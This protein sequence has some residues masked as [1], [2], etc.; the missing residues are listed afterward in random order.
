MAN[1]LLVVLGNSEGFLNGHLYTHENHEKFNT[2]VKNGERWAFCCGAVE[3]N[4]THIREDVGSIL[5]SLSESETQCC[6]GCGI[7]WHL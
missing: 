5:A 3:G 6:C 4:P 2:G 1:Y 7:G